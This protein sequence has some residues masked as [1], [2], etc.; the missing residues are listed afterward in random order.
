MEEY[1]TLSVIIPV[2]DPEPYYPQLMNDLHALLDLMEI[3]HEI[4][5]QKEK[6]LTNA[7][8]EGVK[9]SRYPSIVVMDADGSHDP[10]YVPVMLYYLNKGYD[11]VIGFK[12]V[13]ETSWTR[14][15]ISQIFRMLGSIMLGTKVKDCMSGFVMGRKEIFQG[16]KGSM[17]YKFLLQLLIHDPKVKEI[18]IT[19]HERKMGKSKAS[20]LTG[21]RTL[22]NICKLGVSRKTRN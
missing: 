10:L 12:E 3:E 7:I 15:T 11:L 4:L 2:K 6:G 5:I 13:D 20:L 17:G 21:L 9:R 16:I 1:K 18:P 19:F 22:T 8:V 14:K